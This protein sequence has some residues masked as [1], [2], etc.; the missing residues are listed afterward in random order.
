MVALSRYL[1]TDSGTP[2]YPKHQLY[3]HTTDLRVRKARHL[4]H[5][6]FLFLSLH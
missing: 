3:I 2:P 1:T 6:Y 4:P 5:V